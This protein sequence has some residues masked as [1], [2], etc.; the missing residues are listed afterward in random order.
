[1]SF[2][3]AEATEGPAGSSTESGGSYLL[4]QLPGCRGGEAAEDYKGKNLLGLKAHFQTSR[5]W[6]LLP[7]LLDDFYC[8]ISTDQ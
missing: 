8:E 5:E 1:M 3:P 2:Q 7:E 6:I 4:H